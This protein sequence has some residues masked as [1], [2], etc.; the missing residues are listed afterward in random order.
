MGHNLLT[1]VDAGSLMPAR[2]SLFELH[3]HNNTFRVVPP[4]VS[5]MSSLK[6]LDLSNNDLGDLPPSLGV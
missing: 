1:A 5:L 4:E 6:V 3:L 2:D